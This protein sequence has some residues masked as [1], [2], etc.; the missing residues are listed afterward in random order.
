MFL[1]L[2]AKIKNEIA[3]ISYETWFAE[4]KLISLRDNTATVLVPYHS[5]KKMLI[6]NYKGI[7]SYTDKMILVLG[8]KYKNLL[9]NRFYL[10]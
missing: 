2:K 8:K 3:T 5:Q 10:I 4:T 1:N 7:I 6:E 9:T